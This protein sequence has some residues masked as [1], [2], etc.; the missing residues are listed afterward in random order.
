M[1]VDHDFSDR[2]HVYGIYNASAQHHVLTR[3]YR[4]HTP[5]LALRRTCRRNDTLSL[6]YTRTFTNNVINE[7]RGG[8]NHQQA[9]AS[10]QHHPGGFLSSI[11]FD[12]SDIDAYGGS[13]WA[14]MNLDTFGHPAVSFSNT[15]ATFHNG[16]RNTDRPMDQNLATFGDTLTWVIGK[17]N[18]KMGADFVRN[19]AIDGFAVNRGN[20]RGLMTYTGARS[21]LRSRNFLLGE[22]PTSV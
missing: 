6:S 13:G 12:Q 18:L 14:Q 10:Q 9:R 21:R 16:G 17:H 19:A 7:A 20:P 3:W 5:G 1:R 4:R 2:D 8:F 15:F 11:G 22:P